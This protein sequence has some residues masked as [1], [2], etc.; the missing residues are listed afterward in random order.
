MLAVLPPTEALV[1]YNSRPRP[2]AAGVVAVVYPTPRAIIFEI[3]NMDNIAVV[4]CHSHQFIALTV[5][6]SDTQG[7]VDGSYR[8]PGIRR[9]AEN[10]IF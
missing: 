9:G 3:D 4:D 1:I 5:L 7:A 10:A 8:S 6:I 2:G